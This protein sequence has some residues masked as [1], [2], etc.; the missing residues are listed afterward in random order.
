MIINQVAAGSG[1]GGEPSWVLLWSGTLRGGFSVSIPAMVNY[2][3]IKVCTFHY[4]LV[5]EFYVDITYVPYR[6]PPFGGDYGSSVFIANIAS[7][8]IERHYCVAEVDNTKTIFYNR[9]MG[10]ELG[11]TNNTR[12]DSV[13]YFV[14]QVWGIVDNIPEA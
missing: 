9:Q 5:S 3:R 14:Y 4:N 1:G 6:K 11:S 2:T 13:N 7:A 12:N 8:S 10:Y